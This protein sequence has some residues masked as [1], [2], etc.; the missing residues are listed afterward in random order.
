MKPFLDS[1]KVYGTL[2]Y[3]IE[4]VPLTETFEELEE[5]NPALANAWFNEAD[6]I[7]NHRKSFNPEKYTD[8]ELYEEY[9]GLYPE[10]GKVVAISAGVFDF[11]GKTS[12]MRLF[13]KTFM[14]EKESII[15]DDF[16]SF[17]D[18]VNERKKGFVLGGYNIKVFDNPFLVKRYAINHME[19]PEKLFSIGKKPW[20]IHD[21]DIAEMWKIGTYD[22][23]VKLD[24]LTGAFG[25][26]SPKDFMDGS[27]VSKV[28]YSDSEDK[29]ET[30]GEYCQGD[31]ESVAELFLRLS[32]LG[33]E[34]EVHT[35]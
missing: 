17:L 34:F 26:E 28:F 24:C 19:I 8:Q 6:N 10:F 9:G 21:V 33:N 25:I 32:D 1:K 30:I 23:F 14:G 12:T 4:T 16:H 11:D 31:V 27:Q 29:L 2:I 20:E 7:R 35:I 15:L 18:K 13:I 3:D 5:L 22:K